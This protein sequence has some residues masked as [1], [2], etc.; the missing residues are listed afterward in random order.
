MLVKGYAGT[1]K[2]T[3]I[4]E[5]VRNLPLINQKFLLLAPT[6]RAAKVIS[7]YSG[8][9]AFT[10]HKIIY[11]LQENQDGRMQFRLQKSYQKQ[12]IFIVDEASMLSDQSS[13]GEKGLL[14]DLL[15]YVFAE[16]KGNKLILI[17]D[18]A[19]LPPIGQESSSALQ[20]NVLQHKYRLQV[21][22]LELKEVVRQELN[23]GILFNA[24]RLRNQLL[25]ESPIVKFRSRGFRDFYFMGNGKMEDGLRYAY[26]KYGLE[27][28]IIICRSN[29]N[30][31]MYNQF[32]RRQLFYYENELEA[33]DQLMVVKNNYFYMPEDFPTGF[34]ANGDMV[35]IKRIVD[36]EERYGFRFATLELNLVDFPDLP[37]FEAKVILDTLINR[38]PGLDTGDQQKIYQAVLAELYEEEEEGAETKIRSHP[39]LNALQIKFAYAITCHKAQGGQWDAV[40]IDHGYFTEDML[41]QDFIRWL[42]TAITRASK[43]VYLVNFPGTFLEK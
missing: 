29:R 27:N 21:K 13:F 39:F 11:K 19:Q 12:T 40:F 23:S 17:G 34:L 42:Y 16:D 31:E 26:Q 20:Q 33:G 43:E 2:T 4:S 7:A 24:T 38:A 25:Q 10:I 1:G 41:N 22:G 36:F 8:R 32:I 15:E 3:L 35:S 28:T 5:L 14:G 30:A 18:T 6:G 9:S 37:A